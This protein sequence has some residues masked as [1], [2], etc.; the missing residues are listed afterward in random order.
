MEEQF[1]LILPVVLLAA[2]AIVSRR[3][4]V[5]GLVGLAVAATIEAVIVTP[6]ADPARLWA[7]LDTQASPIVFGCVAALVGAR[8]RGLGAS[9]GALACC[10]VA[11]LFHRDGVQPILMPVFAAGAALVVLHLAQSGNRLLGARLPVAIG[12]RSYGIYLYHL[13]LFILVGPYLGVVLTTGAA[14]LSWRYIERPILGAR[15]RVRAAPAASGGIAC[16]AS[17]GAIQS[18]PWRSAQVKG[19]DSA[20]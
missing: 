10:G 17:P 20:A 19:I 15:R 18:T 13:P 4:L 5:M 11:V 2:L 9:I 1:Y 3:A 6:G 16:Q 7:G 8:P 14:C 12:K